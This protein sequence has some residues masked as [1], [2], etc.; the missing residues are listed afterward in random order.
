M[1]NWKSRTYPKPLAIAPAKRRHTGNA[2]EQLAANYLIDQGL[3][4]LSSNY[5]CKLGEIDL[6]MKHREV[7]VFVEVRYRLNSD[8]MSPV[9]SIN[10]RKQQKLLRTAQAYLKQHHL[11]DAVPC[12]IDVV[13]ITP[14]RRVNGYNFDWITNAIQPGI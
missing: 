12:R 14:D 7:L 3:E 5:Q 4:L 9:V 13:G 2:F 10:P 1:S 6:I 8:F 11:T